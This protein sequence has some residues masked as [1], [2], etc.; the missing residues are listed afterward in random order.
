MRNDVTPQEMSRAHILSWVDDQLAFHRDMITGL[1]GIRERLN[2]LPAPGPVG[3]DLDA[4]ILDSPDVAIDTPKSVWTAEKR[5][6]HARK[7]RAA[8]KRRKGGRG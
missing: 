7:M 1:E 4:E 8:W 6:A 5:A 3:P 2:A